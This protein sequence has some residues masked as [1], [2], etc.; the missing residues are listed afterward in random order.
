MIIHP[1]IFYERICRR[2]PG[3]SG[4]GCST[5]LI[6]ALA[7]RKFLQ[8]P[9]NEFPLNRWEALELL[10]GDLQPYVTF[11]DFQEPLGQHC[12]L[13]QGVKEHQ[14]VGQ[15]RSVVVWWSQAIIL[16]G[17]HFM[18]QFGKYQWAWM[19]E[20]DVQYIGHWGRQGNCV[21]CCSKTLPEDHA[22]HAQVPK[23]CSPPGACSRL[24]D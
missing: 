18:Q 12:E 17:L 3:S 16:S 14:D 23:H 22:T 11:V 8:P 15:G 7:I 1:P 21:W 5:A 2:H 4:P 20:A 6:I 9:G 10:P 24:T 19:I 13:R